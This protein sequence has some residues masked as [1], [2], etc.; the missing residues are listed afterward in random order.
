MVIFLFVLPA[1][2]KVKVTSCKEK[3]KQNKNFGRFIFDSLQLKFGYFSWGISVIL[4]E[5]HE[6]KIIGISSSGNKKA[7]AIIA[8]AFTPKITLII[9][10]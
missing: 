1:D 8:R 9:E 5:P 3:D 2:H 7:L 4:F 6:G 10:Y